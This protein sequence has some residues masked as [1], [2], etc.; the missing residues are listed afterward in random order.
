MLRRL[1]GR[2]VRRR[3]CHAVATACT[4]ISY[5]LCHFVFS[6][7]SGYTPDMFHRSRCGTSRA[8]SVLVFGFRSAKARSASLLL[9]GAVSS[10][11][12]SNRGSRAP[13]APTEP[14]LR[15]ARGRPPSRP[16]AP[17]ALHC[18]VLRHWGP[19]SAP[20]FAPGRCTRST[21]GVVVR[22]RAFFQRLPGSRLR[23]V[24]AGAAP[25]S[26]QF[27]LQTSLKRTGMFGKI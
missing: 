16:A 24:T 26:R 10:F 7:G 6:V 11:T 20:A 3:G 12:P 4:T 25:R 5:S 21:R 8:S 9:K 2:C 17:T 23:I 13:M 14:A 18:G 22:R 15:R 1:R 27:R 19:S